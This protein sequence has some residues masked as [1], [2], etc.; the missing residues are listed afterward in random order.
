M[1]GVLKQIMRIATG[2]TLKSFDEHCRA[3]GDT[4]SRV[5]RRLIGLNK[6]SA[7]GRDH[8]FAGIKTMS[9]FQRAVP[10]CTYEDLQPYIERALNGEPHQLTAEKPV[11]FATTSGTTGAS[12]YIPVTPTSR[13]SKS[14]LMRVW[15]GSLFKDH[16]GTLDG[17]IIAVVSPEAESYSPGGIPCGAESGHGYRAMSPAVRTQYSAPYE[18]AE[19]KDYEARYYALV[20]I[21]CGQ[22]V[23]LIFACNPSTVLLLAQKMGA[24]T[25]EII[26]DVRDGT[27]SSNFDIA[28][29]IRQVIEPL[30]APDPQ[31]ATE[32]EAAAYR[33]GGR[34]LPR[35]VWPEL[36]CV[37]C[38][39]GGTV[40]MYLDRF[41][42]YVDPATPVRDIGYFASEVRGSVVLS[43]EGSSGVLSVTENL[44]EFAPANGAAKPSG[45]ELLLPHQLEQ[46]G[47]YFIYV[48]TLAGLYRYEMNDLME[49]TGFYGQTPVLRFLHKGKGMVSFTGEK[50]SES[51]VITAVE[52]G[53]AD[54]RGAFE[55]IAAIG[56][57]PD[58]TPRYAFL[59]EFNEPLGDDD[60]HRMLRGIEDALCELNVEYGAKR[61]SLRIDAPVLRTIRPGAF[62]D[63]RRR[64]V[65]KGRMDGQFKTLRLTTNTAFANEFEV[66]GEVALQD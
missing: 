62:N 39:K 52:R 34:L 18:V 64:E 48:T 66:E 24:R 25:E 36:A 44:F 26:K 14:K 1:D 17:K 15:L 9:D 13:A 65:E 53:L 63:Y 33:G 47:Q 51:Q 35:T 7:F 12:K 20:R 4:Q 61:K 27:L 19:I 37:A 3:L 28:P 59:V 55:F 49:V 46:G 60:G 23:S 50:L 11:M 56:E 42:D 38:W 5:L 31:R 29:E 32:L 21:A 57:V 2:S 6:S 58:E 41:G 30:L 10:V 40:G 54:R 22:S 8:G 45:D 43:D 16:P